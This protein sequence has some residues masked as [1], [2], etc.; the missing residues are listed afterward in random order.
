[1]DKEINL[2][3]D[4][5]NFKYYYKYASAR[6]Y[7]AAARNLE[8]KAIKYLQE[9]S[10]P[11]FLF[12]NSAE[13]KNSITYA[14]ELEM[15]DFLVEILK[16]FPEVCAIKDKD[17]RNLLS[18]AAKRGLVG[19]SDYAWSSGD[20]NLRNLVMEKDNRGYS[21]ACY[22]VDYYFKDKKK[23]TKTKNANKPKTYS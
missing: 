18:R 20:E 4:F 1:M 23:P 16:K 9:Q 3:R 10:D 12:K 2:A 5:C 22:I 8:R 21:A 14:V 17:N 13:N 7:Y 6:D 15:E 11:N 19:M